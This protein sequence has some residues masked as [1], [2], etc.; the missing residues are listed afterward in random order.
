MERIGKPQRL[1][2]GPKGELLM[3]VPILRGAGG[4]LL[5][6]WM[7]VGSGRKLEAVKA[8]KKKLE[9]AS[10]DIDDGW[11]QWDDVL[12]EEFVNYA[13]ETKFIRFLCP[14]CTAFI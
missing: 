11:G 3:K 14:S 6:D 5:Q 13:R 1:V 8:R 9:Q 7:T 2:D 10:R 4:K 12:S